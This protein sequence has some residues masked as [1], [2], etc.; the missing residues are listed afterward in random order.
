MV[1]KW[2]TRPIQP[3]DIAIV[4]R[5]YGKAN[6]F[7][8]GRRLALQNSH[9]L[10]HA[11]EVRDRLFV[12]DRRRRLSRLADLRYVAAGREQVECHSFQFANENQKSVSELRDRILTPYRRQADR[13]ARCP[14]PNAQDII[15]RARTFEERAERTSDPISCEHYREMAA[16]YRSLAVEHQETK[17]TQEHEKFQLRSDG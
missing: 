12:D 4:G 16:H 13:I 15:A 14:M 2:A 10:D 11:R 9:L 6:R 1:R 5:G 8:V 3:N 17:V 7:L